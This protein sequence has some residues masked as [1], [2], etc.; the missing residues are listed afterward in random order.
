MKTTALRLFWLLFGWLLAIP[1]TTWGQSRLSA[2]DLYRE[3][4]REAFDNHEYS[5]A[6]RTCRAALELSPADAD[7]HVFLGRLYAWTHNV[8][9]ARLA[10]VTTL[11]E[12]AGYEDACIAWSDLE[13]WNGNDSTA[14]AVCLLGLDAHPLSI[15]LRQRRAKLLA[16]LHRYR[17]AGKAIDSLV[18]AAPQNTAIRSLAGRI[19]EEAAGNKIGLA[20]DLIY[21]DRQYHDPWHL[22]SLEY[23]RQTRFGSVIGWF[24]YA[25]RFRESGVQFETEAYPH[26][27][28]FLYGYIDLGYSP[29]STLFPAWRTGASLYANLPHAFE[30][31]A[32]FRYLYFSSSTWLYTF[33]IGKYYRNLWFNARCYLV[34]GQGGTS[35]SVTVTTRYYYGGA[36]DYYL[37]AAGTGISPDDNG[38]IVQFADPHRLQTQKLQ[39]GWR[40]L[41]HGRHIVFAGLQWLYQEYLPGQHGHQWDLNA[42][43]LYRF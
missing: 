8:D 32:G 6:I 39:G 27:S 40:H 21:F 34:P 13:S 15:E 12:H 20:Y 14:F 43:Y 5:A 31:D 19:H 11:R 25:N 42:G 35:Q 9:S 24:N 18:A 28:R 30:A 37:L 29:Q 4:R 16:A 3:A 10:F 17:E 2:E 23:S 7:I 41:I 1:A 26:I 36:D 22:A 38:A 33:S